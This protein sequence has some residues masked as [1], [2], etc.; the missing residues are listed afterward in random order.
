MAFM[1]EK[2]ENLMRAGF[3]GTIASLWTYI[4]YSSAPTNR[5]ASILFIISIFGIY[6][7]SYLYSKL[8]ILSFILYELMSFLYFFL[9][10]ELQFGDLHFSEIYSI[11]S[12]MAVLELTVIG[13]ALMML[14]GLLFNLFIRNIEK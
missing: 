7:V 1:K 11:E 3:I 9:Y 12:I 10:I 6:I 14:C 4:F 8:K 5:N 2:I 13:F